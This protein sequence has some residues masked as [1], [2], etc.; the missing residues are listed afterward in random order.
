MNVAA[1]TRNPDLCRGVVSAG[2]WFV[3]DGGVNKKECLKYADGTRH[4]IDVSYSWDMATFLPML[5][6]DWKACE[7][8]H[9]RYRY[10]RTE[11]LEWRLCANYAEHYDRDALLE[12]FDRLPDFR[13]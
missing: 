12:R 2:S 4:F 6:Y 3:S 7:Q 5:G 1:L 11:S 13:Y 8:L 10:T 9:Q